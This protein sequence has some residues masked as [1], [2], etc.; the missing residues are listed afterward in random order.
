MR[1]PI[2]IGDEVTAAGY[3]LAGLVTRVPGPGTETAVVE[4]ASGEADL[5]LVTAEVAEQVQ[6]ERLGRLFSALRPLLLV[7]TDARGR[8]PVPDISGRLRR[9]VGVGE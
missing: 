8:V 2:F 1:P 6:E 5:V 4:Q 9:Q 3:R 7:V